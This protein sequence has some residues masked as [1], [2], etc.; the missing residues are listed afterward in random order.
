MIRHPGG[1]PARP[2]GRRHVTVTGV[3]VSP[4]VIDRHATV[5]YR[6]QPAGRLITPGRAVTTVASAILRA[7]AAVASGLLLVGGL[8]LLLW[9][10]TPGSG[11]DATGLLG[12]SVVAFAAGHFLPVSIGGVAV[13]VHPLLLT[14]I[15]VAVVA[16]SAGRARPVRG[17][18][19]EALH[20]AVF[21]GAYAVLTQQVTAILAPAGAVRP[22]LLAPLCVAVVGV[23]LG[24]ALHRTA[25]NRWWRR[26][27]PH[28]LR[29]GLR[30]GLA[31]TCLLLA[32]GAL[33]VVA[34]LATSFSDATA[35]ARLAA[36]SAGDGFGLLLLCL[37]FLPNAVVAGVGYVSGAGFTIGGGSFSPLVAQTT[38][39][40]A[41][42]LLAAVPGGAVSRSE[43]VALAA[44]VAAAVL[45]AVVACRLLAT[46]RERLAAS[47]LGAGIAG[48]VV[49]GLAAAARGGVAH[50]PW[51]S[52]GVPPLLAGGLVAGVLLVIAVA[53]SA[54]SG[55]R[56]VAW[57][58]PRA[59]EGRRR[60]SAA[61]GGRAADRT[62]GDT[63]VDAEGDSVDDRTSGDEAD[64]DG[65][66]RD[67]VDATGTAPSDADVTGDDVT[68]NAD[69]DDAAD[70]AADDAAAEEEAEAVDEGAGAEERDDA[71]SDNGV[72]RDG[73][74]PAGVG[75]AG[76]PDAE[77][78]ASETAAT[79]GSVGDSVTASDAEEPFSS[80]EPGADRAGD[81]STF[82]DGDS[83]ESA[84]P[85]VA[86]DAGD[87]QPGDR[88]ADAG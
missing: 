15:A 55:L 3:P 51:E 13:T 77:P 61:G 12:G 73:D 88:L 43:L 34:G 9:A 82:P 52:T 26:W 24:I 31:A 16:S 23:L 41:I 87:G 19:L 22:G 79:E 17:R 27:A 50:G 64:A 32:A 75:D 67:L 78:G 62:V 63:A 4:P 5:A 58:P 74:G 47:V 76:D 14:V 21:A 68:E 39:L 70:N 37:A 6:A 42:P 44:P 7:A 1:V 10:V 11:S 83:A 20:G 57:A 81:D 35:I 28:W 66:D 33:A 29:A 46:R 86:G 71:G 80:A 56:S 48:L 65:Q 45:I 59:A 60:T 69:E 53:W 18:T 72:R 84:D 85:G 49:A 8:A 38:D 54:V 30:A 2:S 40:P 36:P 25:W